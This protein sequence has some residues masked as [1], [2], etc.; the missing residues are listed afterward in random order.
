MLRNYSIK[1]PVSHLGEKLISVFL[2]VGHRWHKLLIPA[3]RRQ[4]QGQAGLC[5]FKV[6]LVYRDSQGYTEQISQKKKKKKKKRQN[7]KFL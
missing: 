7:R 6:T 1:F 5:E 2:M 3:L 4:R